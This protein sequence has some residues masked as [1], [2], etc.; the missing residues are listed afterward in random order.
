MAFG[1]T[2]SILAAG[3][4]PLLIGSSLALAGR[5]IGYVTAESRYGNGTVRAP[6]R[7][8]EFGRQV[9]LP[10]GNWLYCE[11]SGLL[12]GNRRPC[13]ETLRRESVDFWETQSEDQ[14]IN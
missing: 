10:G 14:G 9:R 12:P 4:A 5:N 2:I 13:T 6:V 8:A 1:K 3:V 7:Q 11:R